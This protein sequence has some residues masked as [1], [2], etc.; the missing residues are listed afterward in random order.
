LRS[1][2]AVDRF[3][4]GTIPHLPFVLPASSVTAPATPAGPRAWRVWREQVR[5]LAGMVLVYLLLAGLLTWPAAIE[6]GHGVPG[7]PRTDLWN[8]LWSFWFAAEGLW[9]GELPYQARLLNHP[10]GGTLMVS[11]PLGVLAMTPLQAVFGLPV[12]YTLLVWWRLTLAGFAAHLLADAVLRRRLP[13]LPDAWA[14][15]WIA[16]VAYASAPVLLTAVHNGTSEAFN[17]GWAALAVWAAYRAACDGGVRRTLL[18][19]ALLLPAAVASWY[20]GVVA[21]VAVGFL[22]LLG[23]SDQPWRRHLGARVGTLVF[24]LMLTAPAAL[25]FQQGATAQTNLVGIKHA[26]ELNGV[27][28]TTGPADPVGYVRGGDFRSPDFRVMSR[29]NENFFHCTYLG[30]VVVLGAGLSLRRR[31]GPAFIWLTGATALILSLG[32]VL[33]SQGSP[34]IVMGDRAIPLPYFLVERTPGFSSLSL[35]YRLAL[36]P[37][38]AGAVLSAV[39]YGAVLARF[40]PRRRWLLLGLVGLILLELRVVSPLGSIPDTADATP[41]PAIRALAAA[42]PGAVLNFPLVG[43]R[44]YLY[45]QTVHHKPVA[46]TLNFPNNRAGQRLWKTMLSAVDATPTEFRKKTAAAAKSRGIRYL[47]VHIDAMARPDMH[48]AAV[49]A[50]RAAYD[51]LPVS[52][53]SGDTDASADPERLPVRTYQLW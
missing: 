1:P 48:D 44:P 3:D 7:A 12:A 29:Y 52:G 14:G 4:P 15:A 19:G 26:Q 53:T 2:C 17:G 36:G 49:Q 47:V 46:G 25:A 18:A 11:D 37:A 10:D 35:L 31:R 41:A 22:A 23:P 16:G 28:R 27:R 50:V 32:P 24:G 39:G 43:G 8:S 34:L 13:D 42:P 21:F 20:A 30:G 45:E 33:V 40:G 51:P 38:L 5:R 6:L 9:S